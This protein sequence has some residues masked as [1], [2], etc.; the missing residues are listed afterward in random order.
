MRTRKTILEKRKMKKAIAFLLIMSMALAVQAK[1]TAS[2]R[3][4]RAENTRI[5]IVG[6]SLV[7]AG[8]G[9]EIGLRKRL[10]KKKA[11]VKTY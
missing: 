2:K 5:M 1:K 7:G 6:D 9:L 4:Y 10:E 8:S 3:R 11:K